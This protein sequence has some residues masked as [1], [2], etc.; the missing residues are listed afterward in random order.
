MHLKHCPKNFLYS[1]QYFRVLTKH[2]KDKELDNAFKKV[3]NNFIID[4]W[5][6]YLFS[7]V[8]IG[9]TPKEELLK[10]LNEAKRYITDENQ[11][12]TL[13]TILEVGVNNLDDLGKIIIEAETFFKQN[14]FIEAAN[15]YEKAARMDESE[16]THYENAAL[17]FYRGEDFDQAE[18]LFRYVLNNFESRNGKSDFLGLLL[19]EKKQLVDACNFWEIAI[20][21][22]YPGAINV[23]QTFCR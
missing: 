5:R 16:Y 19:Y 4:Q 13:R 10:I 7:K 8:Q 14:R 22:K 6:D 1:R 2:K 20:K 15:L 3:K 9:I 21:K 11:F 18:K 23:K 17:S 12:S